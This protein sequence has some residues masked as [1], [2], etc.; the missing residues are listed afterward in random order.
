M[1]KRELSIE[2]IIADDELNNIQKAELMVEHGIDDGLVYDKKDID[3]IK[4][5]AADHEDFEETVKM[6]AD[7]EAIINQRMNYGY[8][9]SYMTPL[10]S[11]EAALEAF[12]RGEA[13]YLLYPDNSEGMAIE[14]YEIETFDGFF[15]I[16]KEDNPKRAKVD[17]EGLT[18][19]SKTAALEMW[20]KDLDVYI[21]GEIALSRD[22]IDSAGRNDN[23]AVP[24][25]QFMA[26]TEFDK[27]AA[28]SK[29]KE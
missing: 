24:D 26:E 28:N 8:D 19:V 6:I 15:G 2:D 27:T 16:E 22:E 5:F 3:A 4:V 29:E 21:N 20:D 13:V 18:T 12:D 10:G 25:Y 23:F 17:A 7:T 14:R 1:Q 9:F 11:K